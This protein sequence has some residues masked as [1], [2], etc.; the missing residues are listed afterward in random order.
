MEGRVV[1]RTIWGEW[2]IGACTVCT[3]CNLCD[4]S[5]IVYTGGLL[6]SPPELGTVQSRIRYRWPLQHR[7]R[8]SPPV[9]ARHCSWQY[10]NWPQS[11]QLWSISVCGACRFDNSLFSFPWS[12]SSPL[13]LN[14]KSL[15]PTRKEKKEIHFYLQYVPGPILVPVR[16]NLP[17]SFLHPHSLSLARRVTFLVFFSFLAYALSLTTQTLISVSDPIIILILHPS[18][19]PPLLAKEAFLGPV[20]SSLNVSSPIKLALSPCLKARRSAPPATRRASRLS[21]P[22]IQ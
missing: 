9:T 17:S 4:R 12:S 21:P 7:H 5:G 14:N 20:H 10:I 2:G 8:L 13:N 1:L 16:L 6:P 15:V 18:W 11:D 3:L 19:L 22:S